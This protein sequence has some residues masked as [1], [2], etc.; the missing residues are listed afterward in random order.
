VGIVEFDSLRIVWSA[1]GVDA[2]EALVRELADAAGQCLGQ[3]AVL[4]SLRDDTFALLVPGVDAAAASGGPV[5]A[6]R[7]RLA[8][9]RFEH[10]GQR[11]SIGVSVGLASWSPAESDAEE[12]LRRA[13]AA[14]MAAR[15]EGRNRVRVYEQGSRELRR[16]ETLSEW[17]GRLDALLDGSGLYLRAQQVRPIADAG[18]LPH[19]EI[20]LGIEPQPG[21][22]SGPMGFVTAVE[23]LGRSHDLDR[24]VI[25]AV[26]D[27]IEANP[28]RFER[29]G[30]FAINVSP[31]SL[32]S[33]TILDLLDERLSR[34][35]IPAGKITFELTETAAMD[36][37]G[38][39][40]DFIQRVRRHGC[41]V[42]L[43]D[44]GSGYASYSHLKNLRTDALKIDGAFV[45]DLLDS[46]S[47]RAMVKSMHDVARS[48]GIRTVAEYVESDAILEALREIG[49]DYAQG[50]A[51]HKPCRIDEIDVG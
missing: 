22:D 35:G 45:R 14:C 9:H 7:A 4:A 49:I 29:I 21:M 36:S 40:Q 1:C 44:F 24:W 39:A 8:D 13:D 23:R 34:P 17:A 6:L 20:L 15:A 43:D 19:Y 48:L 11:F 41:R 12:A 30:G 42:S 26:F 3:G 47:D 25:C 50:Y 5:E 16:H 33:P 32:G 31:L 46:P 28:G 37:Y 2:G 10:G 51:I 27:W 38:V 18:V